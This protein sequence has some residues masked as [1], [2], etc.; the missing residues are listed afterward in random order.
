MES[1]GSQ[2][3][4]NKCEADKTD[5]SGLLPFKYESIKVTEDK[6][7]QGF[8]FYSH[9]TVIKATLHGK[10]ILVC[11]EGFDN[12]T[13]SAKAISE[14]IER[15]VLI[16]HALINSSTLKTSNGWAAHYDEEQAK[17]NAILEVVER[18]AVL[19]Q[20]YSSTPFLEIDSSTLPASIQ[21]WMNAEL[22]K[23]EFPILKILISTKGLGSSVTCVLMNSDGFGV[24]G[25]SS[26]IDL[27]ATI[28]NALGEACRAAH[29]T[30]RNSHYADTEILKNN[31]LGIKINPGAHAVYYSYHEPFPNWMFGEKISWFSALRYWNNR[32]N[33]FKNL[34]IHQF[35][36]ET[37]LSEPVFVC[38]AKNPQAFELSWGP[39]APTEAMKTSAFQRLK[40]NEIN[41]KP[42]PIS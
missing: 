24:C 13:A 30:L 37:I 4:N 2:Q 22:S 34:G 21:L 38:F 39:L 7:P 5:L 9:S 8:R 16:E 19:A 28:E 11:G 26:K 15:S 23:S 41:L 29:L 40:I 12:S 1:L 6:R 42:H 32:M 18:D 31:V 25:H 33:Q 10:E 36:A 14:L 17:L 35:T 27:H 3:I 20:W